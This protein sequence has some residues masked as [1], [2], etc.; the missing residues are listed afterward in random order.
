M[1]ENERQDPP[2]GEVLLAAVLM[3]LLAPVIA[4]GG[5]MLLI[6][7]LIAY[8]LGLVDELDQP[9]EIDPPS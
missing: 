6:V 1:D 9:E 4:I 8:T 7:H 3:G 2:P 5:F